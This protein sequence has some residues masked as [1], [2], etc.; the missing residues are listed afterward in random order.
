[1]ASNALLITPK[2]ACPITITDEDDICRAL[3]NVDYKEKYIDTIHGDTYG[4]VHEL[5][6]MYN[7]EASRVVVVARDHYSEDYAQVDQV[8]LQEAYR[9][10]LH[11]QRV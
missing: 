9:T 6:V 4:P 8:H 1:M 10:W 7:P 3:Q 2:K 5:Y 11:T